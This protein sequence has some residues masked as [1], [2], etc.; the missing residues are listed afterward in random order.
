[1]SIGIDVGLVFA[2]PLAE[3]TFGF[4]QLL[5]WQ[6]PIFYMAGFDL[7]SETP[8]VNEEEMK[9]AKPVLLGNFFDALICNGH[10]RAIKKLETPKTPFPCFKVKI[11][12]K[13]FVESWDRQ[14]IREATLEESRTL[15]FRSNRGPI[16]LENALKAY[17]GLASWQPRYDGLRTEAVAKSS[18]AF[19]MN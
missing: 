12:E 6:R 9:S 4:G 13:F 2:L 18:N 8:N 19:S 1:M 10:W 7:R 14:R 3:K 11:G 17:F 15:E 5:A 16:I